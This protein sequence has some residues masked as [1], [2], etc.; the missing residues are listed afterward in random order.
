MLRIVSTRFV[1]YLLMVGLFVVALVY[2][3]ATGDALRYTDENQCHLLIC[4]IVSGKGY[5]AVPGQPT[6]FRPPGFPCAMSLAYLVWNRPLAAKVVNVVCLFLTAFFLYL[7]VERERPRAGLFVPILV[8]LYP[9]L[10]YTTSTLYPQTL[11]TTLF[12]LVLF[13]LYR[14]GS[15]GGGA[16]L[17]GIVMGMLILTIPTFL[18]FAAVLGI[19]LCVTHKKN[20][21][22]A[23]QAAGLFLCCAFLVVAPWTVRNY[24]VFRHVVPVAT[25]FGF[26]L[27]LGNSENAHPNQGINVDLSPYAGTWLKKM[28][29]AERDRYFAS[30][31]VKWIAS[32]PARAA[33]LYCRK[34]VNYFNFRNE[35]K[36]APESS[37][38]R[39][40][41]NFVTYYA[42]LALALIRLAMVRRYPLSRI[43]A[44]LYIIY[45]GNAFVSAVFFPRIR[46]RIPFD[47]LLVAIDSICLGLI[48][49]EILERR[50]PAT[51]GAGLK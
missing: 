14:F 34:V 46:F 9:V 30:C 39:N 47:V 26:N 33:S 50:R 8:L 29:E 32:N 24:L 5:A 21:R 37:T 2:C 48:T 4:N 19:Y 45:V 25:N 51:Q 43:E 6:A 10:T 15:T 3:V 28:N 7:L 31:A 35:M 38:L 20:V 11:G 23:S 13:L 16:A 22:F 44:L 27:L 41:I 42:L 12:V 1:A 36:T 18:V 49:S 40:G 17:A